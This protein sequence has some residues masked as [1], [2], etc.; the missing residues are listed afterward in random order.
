[1]K[2]IAKLLNNKII[3]KDNNINV[4]R[5]FI[6]NTVLNL[7]SNSVEFVLLNIS[8]KTFISLCS[9]IFNICGKY[10]VLPFVS[11][12]IHTLEKIN[13]QT[14]YEYN[15]MLKKLIIGNTNLNN[16]YIY[17]TDYFNLIKTK[18]SLVLIL[19]NIISS[20]PKLM[21]LSKNL[22][23]WKEK[24]IE[25]DL[26]LWLNANTSNCSNYHLYVLKNQLDLVHQYFLDRLYI[27]LNYS[28]DNYKENK[29]E[30]YYDDVAVIE[31]K[32][33]EYIIKKGN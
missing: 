9:Y 12:Q 5:N 8:Q 23:E 26:K 28:V 3:F 7:Q 14:I 17:Y 27:P 16:L 22:I 15:F 6:N 30:E 32:F 18:T 25:I 1:M 19:D 31:N 24:N 10:A 33:D 21:T 13:I 4:I 29:D 11:Y 20:I 2:I